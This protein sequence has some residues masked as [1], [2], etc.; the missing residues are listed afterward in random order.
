MNTIAD[1]QNGSHLTP[2]MNTAANVQKIEAAEES[3]Q[4]GYTSFPCSMYFADSETD[5]SLKFDT[6]A[7]WH[8]STELLHFERGTF[9]LSI[10]MENTV[11]TGECYA[12]VESGMLHSITS[13]PAYRESALLFSPSVLSTR[14]ID[15][16]EQNLIEPLIHGNLTLPRFI[17]P[18]MP[19][20]AEFDRLYRQIADIFRNADDR[21]DDQFNLSGASDQLRCKALMMLLVSALAESG[22]LTASDYVPDSKVEALKSVLSY[23]NGNYGSKI[24]I[25]DLAELMNFNEQYFSRFFR[26]TVGRTCVDYINNVRVRHAMK[27]LRTTSLPVLDIAYACGFGNIGHFIQTF[28]KATGKKPLEYRMQHIT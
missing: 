2:L 9:S 7:H 15:S 16:S 10:N 8:S 1:I 26:K 18:G 22:L 14:N 4:Q 25:R 20:F 23:I 17:R 28:K 12:F 27:M 21:R 13:E 11:V 3:R 6:K 19:V 24:Y 5:G